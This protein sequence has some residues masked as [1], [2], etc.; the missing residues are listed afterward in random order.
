MHIYYMP[1]AVSVQI[2]SPSPS[3]KLGILFAKKTYPFPPVK[4]FLRINFCL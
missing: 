3:D 2:H 1:T 4:L